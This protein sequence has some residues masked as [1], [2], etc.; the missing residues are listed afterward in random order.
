MGLGHAAAIQ[1][2]AAGE[3]AVSR[4]AITILM[5]AAASIPLAWYPGCPGAGHP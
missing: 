4:L 1:A 3:L 5:V 2:A